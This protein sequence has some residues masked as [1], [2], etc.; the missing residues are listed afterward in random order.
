MKLTILFI[1]LLVILSINAFAYHEDSNSD[2]NGDEA[3][4]DL[5]EYED[6]NYDIYKED[7]HPSLRPYSIAG[8]QPL[9][10]FIGDKDGQRIAIPEFIP[11]EKYEKDNF[12]PRVFSDSYFKEPFTRYGGSSITVRYARIRSSIAVQPESMIEVHII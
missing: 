5:D 11:K 10:I 3:R 6:D 2:D 12:V 7:Y 9:R 4:Y 8:T 1:A